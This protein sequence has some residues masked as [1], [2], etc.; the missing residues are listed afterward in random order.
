MLASGQSENVTVVLVQRSGLPL[1]MIH[2][3]VDASAASSGSGPALCATLCLTLRPEP[4]YV[5]QSWSLRSCIMNFKNQSNVSFV[6]FTGQSISA[7]NRFIRTQRFAPELVRRS[8]AN[9]LLSAGNMALFRSPVPEILLSGNALY[10]PGISSRCK[11]ARWFPPVARYQTQGANCQMVCA[12]CRPNG[13]A[14]PSFCGR[15]ER[16]T[17]VRALAIHHGFDRD[18]FYRATEAL[19]AELKKKLERTSDELR[20]LFVS[21][22]NYYRNFET[23]IERSAYSAGSSSLGR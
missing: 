18:L 23:L 1:S 11:A 20:L 2:L 4:M 16:W 5:P 17:G 6:E 10:N 8:G 7:A 19:P 13:C 12:R 3:F 22:Y 14:E 9:V 15:F 21:H